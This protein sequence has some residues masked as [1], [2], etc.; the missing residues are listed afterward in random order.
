MKASSFRVKL[1]FDCRPSAVSR[2][3]GLHVLPGAFPLGPFIVEESG[4]LTFR[5]PERGAGFSFIWRGRRFSAS[6]AQGSISVT[7]VLGLVPS[8]AA[9]PGKRENALASLRV[10]PRAL[11]SGWALRLT[12]DHR[13]HIKAAEPMEWPAHATDLMSPLVQ[14]LLRLAPY[15]DLMDEAQ[16]GPAN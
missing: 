16:L 8:S 15:L 11:P 5:S 4:K 9:G 3:K 13:I 7:G 6:L 14:F 12:P 1:G 2:Q 10:L